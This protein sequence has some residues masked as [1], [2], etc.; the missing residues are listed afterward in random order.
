M[1]KS[2]FTGKEYDENKSIRLINMTQVAAYMAYGLELLDLFESKDHKTGKHILVA[3][4]DRES[5]NEAYK[6]WCEHKLN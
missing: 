2:R 4:F 1:V 6:L 5:T 3:V